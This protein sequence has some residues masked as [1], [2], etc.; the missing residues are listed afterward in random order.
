MMVFSVN[1]GDYAI[2]LPHQ[3]PPYVQLFLLGLATDVVRR[4]VANWND[5]AVW[6]L[7]T[8]IS[9]VNRGMVPPL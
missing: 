5:N 6:K 2:G 9:V 8:L 3:E 1:Y 4:D 7:S